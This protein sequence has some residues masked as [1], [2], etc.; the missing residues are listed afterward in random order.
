MTRRIWSWLARFISSQLRKLEQY[1]WEQSNKRNLLEAQ[2]II[3][4]NF[5]TVE[6]FDG[7]DT[8]IV[9]S[10]AENTVVENWNTK[11]RK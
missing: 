8:M 7:K 11:Y 6:R 2:L 3:H 10:M 4:E 1:S 5:T 9:S